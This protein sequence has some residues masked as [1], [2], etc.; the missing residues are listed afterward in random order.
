MSYE[1]APATILLNT[2]CAC[3]GKKL[4]D[5]NSVERGI[6]PVCNEK[7][8]QIDINTDTSDWKRANELINKIARKDVDPT[9]VKSWV[10]E[11]QFCGYPKVAARIQE[12]FEKRIEKAKKKAPVKI[13]ALMNDSA[14]GFSVSTPYNVAFINDLKSS[15][16]Y[17]QRRWNGEEKRWEISAFAKPALW[18]CVK[19]HFAGET[20]HGPKGFFTVP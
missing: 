20:A 12:R 9:K 15:V 1:N 19:R 16:E 13:F 14:G 7:Y 3:C 5:A 2:N 11:L 10:T 18:S 17:S 6:G 8:F 4:V